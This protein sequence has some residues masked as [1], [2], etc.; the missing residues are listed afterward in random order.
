M[1][2]S[3]RVLGDPG[4]DIVLTLR[5]KDSPVYIAPGTKDLIVAKPLDKEGLIGPSAVF[6][7]VI[8]E[9]KFSDEAVSEWVW[10][11]GLG[12]FFVKVSFSFCPSTTG[13][14]HTSQHT[15]DGRER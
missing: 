8:C 14:Y 2:G 11:A 7:N 10:C 6:V 13:Y 3:L 4:K 12:P 1:V 15:G 5:E 9:R